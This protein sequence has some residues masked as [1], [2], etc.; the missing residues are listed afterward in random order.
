[1]FPG[2]TV[3]TEIRL[4]KGVK[5]GNLHFLPGRSSVVQNDPFPELAIG[6]CHPAVPDGRS[7]NS[8]E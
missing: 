7:D 5:L 3:T 2:I 1:L 4:E 8:S 6:L